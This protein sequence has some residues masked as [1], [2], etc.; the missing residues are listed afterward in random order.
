MGFLRPKIS[1]RELYNPVVMPR[2]PNAYACFVRSFHMS[3]VFWFVVEQSE[4]TI[5]SVYKLLCPTLLYIGYHSTPQIKYYSQ[6]ASQNRS[7]CPQIHS[8]GPNKVARQGSQRSRASGLAG[9]SNNVKG[10]GNYY[11]IRVQGFGFRVTGLSN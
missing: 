3:S 7:K 1:M 6:A 9:L 11:S 5:H 2:C 10:N 8:W 4:L